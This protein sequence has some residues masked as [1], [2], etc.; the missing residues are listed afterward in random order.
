MTEFPCIT[1]P[2]WSTK[3]DFYALHHIK[4]IVRDASNLNQPAN[5]RVWAD[6]MA[7]EIGQDDLIDDF[8]RIKIKL[9]EI[10]TEDVEKKGVVKPAHRVV[11][12]GYPKTP[13]E[14]G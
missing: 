12:E 4:G 13:R 9:S 3:E 14:A 5:L 10:I 6:K 2:D 8:H 11:L 1:Q 7:A